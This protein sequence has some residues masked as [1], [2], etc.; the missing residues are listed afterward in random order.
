MPCHDGTTLHSTARHS[1]A[2][3]S[4]PQHSTPQHSTTTCPVQRSEQHGV[5]R[6]NA[7]RSFISPTNTAL[8]NR[9]CCFVLF[10]FGAAAAV[11]CCSYCC[12]FVYLF[13]VVTRDGLRGTAL[14]CTVLLVRRRKQSRP[15]HRPHVLP[16]HG[17]GRER[18]RLNEQLS[19][20]TL[21]SFSRISN[22][23][24]ISSFTVPY[25]P[26]QSRTIPYHP[27]LYRPVAIGHTHICCGLLRA[28]RAAFFF[29]AVTRAGRAFPLLAA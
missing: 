27:V 19:N 11:A 18:E 26:V 13:S 23:F 29:P 15:L 5:I 21:F 1:P 16:L 24:T 12:H 25:H 6:T 4:T 14:Y 8:L 9:F 20:A 22:I 28:I 3:H 7:G 10:P 17:T 2:Q